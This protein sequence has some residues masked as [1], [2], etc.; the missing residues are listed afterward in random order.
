MPTIAAAFQSSVQG[1]AVSSGMELLGGAQR[2]TTYAANILLPNASLGFEAY[3][4]LFLKGLLHKEDFISNLR[5]LGFVVPD[6][7]RHHYQ[8]FALAAN[9][10]LQLNSG[11]WRLPHNAVSRTVALS[12]NL[13]SP[14]ELL[15]LFNRKL[16]TA[17]ATES[18]L[19]FAFAGEDRLAKAYMELANQIPGPSDLISFAVRDCFSPDIVQ[20]FQYN[21]ELPTAILPW[22]EKQGLAGQIDMTMPVGSTTTEGRDVRTKPQW[23]DMYWWSHWQLPSVQQGYEMLQRLYPDSMFGPSPYST[24]DTVFSQASLELLQ[25]A[26]DFPPYWRQR[27]QAIAYHPLGRIDIKRMY[28]VGILKEDATNH[29][30]FHAYKQIGYNDIDAKRLTDYVK[31]VARKNIINPTVQQI[32]KLVLA[33]G[34]EIPTA[35]QMLKDLFYPANEIDIHISNLQLQLNLETIDKISKLVRKNYLEGS[36]TSD[37]CKAALRRI[38]ITPQGIANYINLWDME[39]AGTYR[40]VSA[41]KAIKLYKEGLINEIMLR[42]RLTNLH[43]VDL[44]INLLVQEAKNEVMELQLKQL[45]TLATRQ[46]KETIKAVKEQQK[47]AVTSAKKQEADTTKAALE[48]AKLTKQDLAAYSDKNIIAFFKGGFFDWAGVDRVLAAKGWSPATIIRWKD[49]YLKPLLSKVPNA[50]QTT[51]NAP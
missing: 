19:H 40:Y 28:S 1:F 51:P 43:Y 38:G 29:D 24:P 21:K 42:T 15:T 32:D 36:L 23:F 7:N 17:E 44:D 30:V 26:N 46:Q 3:A 37:E 39:K 31:I 4:Q 33:G 27:L 16:I 11:L 8:M 41:N 10:M 48:R 22:M 25:K 18:L 20:T 5:E 49:T 14:D 45:A 2:A 9:G 6:I 47:F 34:I 12:K 50:T 13:P 35:K